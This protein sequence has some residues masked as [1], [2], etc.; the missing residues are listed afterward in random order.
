M[1]N[2]IKSEDNLLNRL[3]KRASAIKNLS[4]LPQLN[5]TYLKFITGHIG[6]EI[7]PDSGQVVVKLCLPVISA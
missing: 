6:S 4:R 7:T 3:P 1:F 5:L 2:A